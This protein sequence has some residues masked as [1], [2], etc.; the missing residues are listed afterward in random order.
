MTAPANR[1]KLGLFVVAG[2]AAGIGMLTW[3]GVQQLERERSY[4]YAYFDEAV[5]GLEEG[6]PVKFRGI[7]I[8]LVDEIRAAPDKRHLEVRAALDVEKVRKL[9]LDAEGLRDGDG[10]PENLRAQMVMSWVTGTAFVQVDFFPDPETGP[11]Q[12]PFP[13]RDGP[14][15]LRTVKS[16]AKS[17]EDASREVLREL[18]SM[19]TSARELVELLRAELQG[20]RL[21]EVSRQLQVL[22]QQLQALVTSAEQQ[23]LLPSMQRAVTAIG[24]A[25]SSL[26]DDTSPFGATLAELRGLAQQLQ[27]E[28]TAANL[29][30]TSAAVRDATAAAA[31]LGGDVR[32]ELAHLRATLTSIERLMSLLER[33]PASLLRGR[34]AARSPLEPTK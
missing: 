4:A 22:L 9:G 23:Q 17:L 15:T 30:A 7:T 2:A 32:G 14:H 20:V 25:A 1:W 21:P 12:L 6:S 5:N 8:G 18:P 24:D 13:P 19:A 16:T 3:L 26:R 31:Q 33:D 11:Q 28:L 34:T 27:R 10:L 29:P